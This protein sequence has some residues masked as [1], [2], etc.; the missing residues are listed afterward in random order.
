MK[1]LS[2]IISFVTVATV[3]VILIWHTKQTAINHTESTKLIPLEINLPKPMFITWPH[4]KNVPNL[5]KL[6]YKPRPPFMAPV[7]TKNVAIGKPV[8]S[9]D[10]KPIMGKVELIT[11]GN[12]E[13]LDSSYVEFAPFL[14][15]VTIDLEARYNIYA[16]V[17]WHYH[18]QQRAYYDVIVQVADDP[19]FIT[20]VKTIFNNDIDNS[21]GFG[22]GKDMHYVETNEGKLIDAK[23]IKARY[24]RLYSNGNST[25]ELN[26]Y[27]EVEVYGKPVE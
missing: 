10:K 24:I 27:V 14:Q 1:W 7:G 2:I 5:E 26:H 11:D 19:N 18:R 6:S 17:I 8:F 12:K 13:A 22:I 15:H 16:I 21:A 3:A 23:G 25:N 20:N 9:T 4:Y